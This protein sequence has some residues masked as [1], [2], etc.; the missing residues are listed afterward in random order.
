MYA[1]ITRELRLGGLKKELR[2]RL[3]GLKKELRRRLS[4]LKKELRRRLG[5]LKK[6]LKRRLGGPLCCL[7]GRE[8]VHYH[9]VKRLVQ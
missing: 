3:G 1:Y 8:R 2:R 4:G 7:S 6:E 5:G 9:K